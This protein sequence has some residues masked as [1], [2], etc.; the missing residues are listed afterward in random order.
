MSESILDRLPPPADARVSYGP[1]PLHIADLR[2]P[3]GD[4]PFPAVIAIHGGYWRNRYSLDHLGH[5]CA[6]LT[7]QSM[8]TWSIEYRRVG[9]EGGGWPG[10]F[11]DVAAGAEALF[12]FADRLGIDP[13]RVVVVGHSAGGHLASWLANTSRIPVRSLVSSMTLPLRGVVTMAAVLDLR[14]G[15]ALRLG[16]GAIQDFLGGEPDEVPDRYAAGSPVELVPSPVPQT[17]IHGSKD[18]IVPIAISERYVDAAR[19]TGGDASLL[20]L[21]EADHFDVIDPRSPAWPEVVAAIESM[22]GA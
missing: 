15:A 13:D 3:L 18:D 7:A 16:N 9:D 6:A 14:H 4:G 20:A 1:H 11:R 17:V 5:L 21:P 19:R 22:L 12:T 8:A 10:T 2:L